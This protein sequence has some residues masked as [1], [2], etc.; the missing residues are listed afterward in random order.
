MELGRGKTD[1]WV[2]GLGEWS[3]DGP[4][5]Y[6]EG[7]EEGLP[8]SPRESEG[9]RMGVSNTETDGPIDLQ[10][11]GEGAGFKSHCWARLW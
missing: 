11:L 7:L 6:F 9:Q 2:S 3:R 8:C 4:I 5:H 10:W 1:I